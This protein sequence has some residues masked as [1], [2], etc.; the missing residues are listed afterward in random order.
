MMPTYAPGSG[1]G[2]QRRFVRAH[3]ERPGALLSGQEHDDRAASRARS[4]PQS[5]LLGMQWIRVASWLGSNNAV[6]TD[7]VQNIAA[8]SRRAVTT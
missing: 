5:T 7:Q 2:T 8:T 1:A 6:G 4:S 3:D